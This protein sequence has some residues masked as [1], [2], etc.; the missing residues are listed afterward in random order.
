MEKHSEP[1]WQ[2]SPKE[3]SQTSST[4]CSGDCGQLTMWEDVVPACTCYRRHTTP[5]FSSVRSETSKQYAK[6]LREHL[7][8]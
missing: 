2:T 4:L 3:E 7:E 8:S 1:H 5:S 6:R